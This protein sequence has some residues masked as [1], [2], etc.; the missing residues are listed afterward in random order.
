MSNHLRHCP[1]HR[2]PLPCAHCE[3][4][5]KSV[6]VAVM[7]PPKPETPAVV[8]SVHVEIL[9]AEKKRGRPPKNGVIA[10]TAAERKALSR[11]SRK[12]K[13]ADELQQQNT[14][15]LPKELPLTIKDAP[16][17][18]GRLV[19]GGYDSTKMEQVEAKNRLAKHG[20]KVKPKGSS[21][22][23]EKTTDVRETDQQFAKKTFRH[24]S[25]REVRILHAW[26]NDVTERSSVLACGVCHE[27]LA[28]GNDPAANVQ[29]TYDH[30]E[31]THPE[32]FALLAKRL[33]RMRCS[34]DH[35]R[36]TK[37][38]GFGP[39]EISCICGKVLYEPER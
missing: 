35:D 9:P 1:K 31:K 30:F 17:G 19:T 22:D 7:E 37:E 21:P 14:I 34:Q 18:K 29:A 15:S 26:T 11:A 23:T 3:L 39:D 36:L 24:S 27:Q 13:R 2:K 6:Q 12:Q 10:M 25:P 32:Q 20:K 5:Q 4:A 8:V 16:R 28:P 33:D 38:H